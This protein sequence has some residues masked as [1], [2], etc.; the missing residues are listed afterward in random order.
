[1]TAIYLPDPQ[2]TSWQNWTRIVV[3]QLSGEYVFPDELHWREAAIFIS[4]CTP[5]N[6]Q[7]P[8][9]PNFCTDW[10]EWARRLARTDIYGV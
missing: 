1:M 9:D 8:V 2:Y 6:H 3:E 10:R 4:Q 7:P 5:F